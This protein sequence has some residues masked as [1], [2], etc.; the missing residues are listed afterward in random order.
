MTKKKAANE[1][2]N[3]QVRRKQAKVALGVTLGTLVA[4]GFFGGRG[5][6]SKAAHKLHVAAGIGFVGLAYWHWSLYNK[7]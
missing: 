3:I 7:K 2:T 5:V 4:T 1:Q 6:S